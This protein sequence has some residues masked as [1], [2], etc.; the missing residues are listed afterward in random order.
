[1]YFKLKSIIWPNHR[2]PSDWINGGEIGCFL[3]AI[4]SEPVDWG[5]ALLYCVEKGGWLGEIPNEETQKSIL[6]Q[7]GLCT[8]QVRSSQLVPRLF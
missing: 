4:E 8:Q 1:M 2:C 7:S 5:N 6:S 3:F